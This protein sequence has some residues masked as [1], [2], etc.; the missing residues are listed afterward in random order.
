MEKT[1]K[2]LKCMSVLILVLAAISLVRVILSVVLTDFAPDKLPAGTTEGVVL[3]SQIIMC[4][5][6]L[7][8]LV[9]QIYVGLKGIKISN[10]SVSS[11][12]APVVWAIILA[13][14]SALSLIS[15]VSN[16]IQ[17]GI[18][19]GYVLELVDFALDVIIYLAY[20]KYANE[21]LKA[22]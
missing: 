4:V 15:P 8:L 22:A 2:N 5:F 3:A 21:I 13:I 12:K 18:T 17:N 10:D 14:L 9:P 19:V 11:T 1:K 6:G 16:L 20:I 7:A